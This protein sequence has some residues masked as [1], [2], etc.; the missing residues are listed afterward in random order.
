[1]VQKRSECGSRDGP[2]KEGASPKRTIRPACYFR[3]T[4][5]RARIAPR[6]SVR[7]RK[8]R[9]DSRPSP[10]TTTVKKEPPEMIHSTVLRSGS[11]VC[12]GKGR[13]EAGVNKAGTISVEGEGYMHI[14]P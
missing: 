7:L 10:P 2:R 1:M 4:V 6:G 12:H 14:K 5:I 3:K 9:Q 8:I 13:K 11:R